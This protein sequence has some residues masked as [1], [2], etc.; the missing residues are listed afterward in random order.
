DASEDAARGSEARHQ[1]ETDELKSFQ[2]NVMTNVHDN[3]ART[4]AEFMKNQ[5]FGPGDIEEIMHGG[6]HVHDEG[7]KDQG[8]LQ[9]GNVDMFAQGQGS[10]SDERAKKQHS[11]IDPEHMMH[12]GQG[13]HDH[14]PHTEQVEAQVQPGGGAPADNLL[15][16]LEHQESK[17]KSRIVKE[18]KFKRVTP[19][20]FHM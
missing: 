16:P 15:K 5:Q 10:N 11:T 20:F 12:A 6:H 1:A 7:H 13:D 2:P 14:N 4:A 8:P 17:V 3:V 9:G 18:S 19:H